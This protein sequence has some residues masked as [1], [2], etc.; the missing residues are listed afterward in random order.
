Q[1]ARAAARVLVADGEAGAVEDVGLASDLAAI[2]RER[3][4]PGAPALLPFVEA[5]REAAGD[6]WRDRGD[7]P[8]M[9]EQREA[10]GRMALEEADGL[11][12]PVVQIARMRMQQGLVR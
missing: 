9:A 3:R 11:H 10:F 12:A 6:A 1:V 5:L 2:A 8:A 4:W 7:V